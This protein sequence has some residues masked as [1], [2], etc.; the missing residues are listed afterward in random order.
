VQDTERTLQMNVCLYAMQAV[1]P[2]NSVHLLISALVRVD[3]SRM[4]ETT[5]HL[6]VQEAAQMA[7][8]QLLTFALAMTVL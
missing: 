7:A 1:H 5:A 3:M 6:S 2:I 8:V 4:G